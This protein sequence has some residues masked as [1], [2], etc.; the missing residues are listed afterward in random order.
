MLDKF[1]EEAYQANF[2]VVAVI[3]GKGR[4]NADQPILKNKVNEWLRDYANV[5]AFCSAS[6]QDGGTG[7]V[8]I[9]L[10]KSR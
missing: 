5:I 6:P 7:K 9:M 8:Y 4:N 1:I 2:F 10:E 3:H